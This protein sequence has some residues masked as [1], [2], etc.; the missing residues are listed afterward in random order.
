MKRSTEEVSENDDGDDDYTPTRLVRAPRRKPRGAEAQT[1]PRH[2]VS[3][4]VLA[5]SRWRSS[6]FLG[7]GLPADDTYK[8]NHLFDSC[9]MLR[10]CA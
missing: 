5:A 6:W 8:Y 3:L 7:G 10:V 1:G 9:G 2:D 4:L